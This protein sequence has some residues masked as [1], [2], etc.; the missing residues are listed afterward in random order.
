MIKTL[1]K[2]GI[3]ILPWKLKRPVLEKFFEYDL[4]RESRIGIAWVFPKKLIMGQ[5]ATIGHCT[6]CKEIDLLN[7]GAHSSIGRL[8]WITGFPSHR[9]DFFSHQTDRNPELVMEVHSALTN[10]HLVDCTDRV[11]IRKFATVA[12]F[13]SQILTHSIDL[14]ENRQHSRPIEIGSYCFV[15]TN[16][17]ILGGSSLP[18][19]SVLGAK[20]LLNKR[21][22]ETHMLYGGVPA[23][24]ICRVPPETKYFNRTTGFVR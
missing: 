12:G 21:H 6:V 8:N 3:V 17:V 7:M 10:R 22:T 4:H 16:S 5:G 13:H 18:D 15:G 23:E 2:A 9:S 19:F 14:A 24:P 1:L 11:T 20:S